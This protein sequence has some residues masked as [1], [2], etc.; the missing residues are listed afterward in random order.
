MGSG[1]ARG[2]SGPPADPTSF[3]SNAGD[4]VMLPR[5][6]DG[7]V[8]AFPLD[9]PSP[10]EEF[11]WARLWKAPQAGQWVALSLVDEVAFYC[12]YLAEAEAPAASSA[13]R[14]LVKQHQELLGIS[15]AGMARLKWRLAQDE[16]APKRE[17]RKTAAAKR[18]GSSRSRLKVVNGAAE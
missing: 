5:S 11:W 18:S 8:P 16:V 10:R 15:T 7:P 1:G 4:W 17:E 2:R 9:D 13:V 3:R 14:T 12:R 6:Y